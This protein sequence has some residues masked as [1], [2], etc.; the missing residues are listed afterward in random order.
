MQEQNSA[1]AD[2]ILVKMDSLDN[3]GTIDTSNP[4]FISQSSS[5]EDWLQPRIPEFD[6]LKYMNVNISLSQ[7]EQREKYYK[8]CFPNYRKQFQHTIGPRFSLPRSK[9]YVS[10]SI[11]PDTL[12]FAVATEKKWSVY[13]TPLDYNDS[14]TL[15]SSGRS[16]GETL[17]TL[18]EKQH[19]LKSASSLTF[20]PQNTAAT[21]D[22]PPLLTSEAEQAALT[23]WSHQIISLS[24]R[25]LAIA[26]SNGILRMYDM[27]NQGKC[28]YHHKSKFNI[29]YMAIS[30][31]GS[32]IACAIT[33]IDNKTQAEQPMIVLHWLQLGDTAPLM[34]RYTN[35]MESMEKTSGMTIQIV[36]TVT[37]RIPYKDVINCLSFSWDEAFLSCGTSLTSHI[38]IIN[39][40]NPHEPRMMLKT[41]RWTD[42]KPESEG[43]TSIEFFPRSRLLAITSV[44]KNSYPMIID[45]KIKSTLSESRTIP[46][47]S[48][49]L[50]VEKVGWS[51]HRTSIS[52]RGNAAAFLDK[53]GLVYLM[54]APTFENIHK[55]ILVVAEVSSAPTYKE[56]AAMRFSPTGHALFIIDRKGNFH[57][58]DFAAGSPQQAGISKCRILA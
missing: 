46:P 45:T 58:E 35:S 4:S 33:G 52:P 29:G 17:Q 42:K 23:N 8:K 49:I 2:G 16:V 14:P 10:S 40:T 36:E 26:G 50:R 55:R 27:E 51:I 12:K 18:A 39:V 48:M 22:I 13:W 6:N 30:P 3:A 31:N 57:V 37:I 56:A 7:F 11:S 28:V 34:T 24:N 20:D 54:Y 32:L 5:N 41:S 19:G 1:N 47:L 15:L 38:L 43:I 53:N 9:T 25:Y 21:T 44:A